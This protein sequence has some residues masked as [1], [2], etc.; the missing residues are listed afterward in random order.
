MKLKLLFLLQFILQIG[1]CQENKTKID[2]LK[3]VIAT[4]K[5]DTAKVWTLIALG[6]EIEGPKPYEAY[7]YYKQAEA[8]SRKINYPRGII[9]AISNFTYILDSQ[10][11]TEISKPFYEEAIV[12][13]KNNKLILLEGSA[14]ANLGSWYRRN[15]DYRTAIEYYFK[16]SKILDKINEMN[17]ATKLKINIVNIYF[18]LKRFKEGIKICEDLEKKLELEDKSEKLLFQ[19]YMAKGNC[20]TGIRKWQEAIDAYQKTMKIAEK[21]N[22]KE[23]IVVCRNNL[24]TCYREIG[25]LEKSLDFAKKA[26]LVSK[27]IGNWIGLKTGNHNIGSFFFEKNKPDSAYKYFSESLKTSLKYNVIDEIQETYE[28]LALVSLQKGD[29]PSWKKYAALA[30]SSE[31]KMTGALVQEAA[32]DIESK[33]QLSQKQNE[34]LQKDISLQ[35][36]R[37]NMSWLIGGFSLL[38]VLS[39]LGFYSF[40]KKQHTKSLEAELETQRSERQRIASEMHDELGGNLTSLMY[41]AHNLKDKATKNAQVDKI[42]QTS[43]NISESINEIVWALNQEQNQ[44][45]DWVFYVRGKTAELFENAG[46]NYKFNISEPVPERTLSNIEKRNLY[47]VVKEGINN[48]LKHSKASNYEVN[49]DFESNINIEIKDNGIGFIE[50]GSPKA[51]GGNG[52]K[53]MSRRMEEIGGTIAWSNGEGTSVKIKI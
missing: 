46:V 7:I 34:I 1:F 39:G 8:I 25:N 23:A 26:I 17:S 12:L 48:A 37:N 47:L 41:L 15:G 42:I 35:K 24:S 9:K 51:G 2:S 5:A 52:L 10:N 32:R 11:K 49:M 45:S 13:A 14:I 22:H 29:L 36:S 33:Y 44:L 43:G 40:R 53:N 3:K 30:D 50:N 31:E 6:N 38:S 19:V 21:L 16:A 28:G 18:K 20:F 4:T 27:E